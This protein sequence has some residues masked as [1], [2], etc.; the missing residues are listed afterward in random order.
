MNTTT[1]RLREWLADHS[2]RARNPVPRVRRT[3]EPHEPGFRLE[4]KYK[5]P[6]S[7]RFFLGVVSLLGLM[8]LIP[9]IIAMCVVAYAFLQAFF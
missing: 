7:T 4:W 9:L 8:I 2:K 3:D 5:M 1:L 6:L